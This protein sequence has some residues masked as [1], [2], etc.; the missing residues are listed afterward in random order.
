MSI[1]TILRVL[2]V[3]VFVSLAVSPQGAEA[4]SLLKSNAV[5]AEQM[6]TEVKSTNRYHWLRRHPRHRGWTHHLDPGW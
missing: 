1:E 4:R 2:V 5:T 6:T 3:G